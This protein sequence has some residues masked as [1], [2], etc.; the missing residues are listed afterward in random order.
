MKTFL[1][2]TPD[3]GDFLGREASDHFHLPYRVRIKVQREKDK[4]LWNLQPTV[5]KKEKKKFKKVTQYILNS[6]NVM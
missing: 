2:L 4:C 3:A 5:N 1:Q 6:Q